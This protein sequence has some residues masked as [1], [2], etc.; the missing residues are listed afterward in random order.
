MG[1]ILK[2]M[3]EQMPGSFFGWDIFLPANMAKLAIDL[4]ITIEAIFFFSFF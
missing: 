1:N 3:I 4:R 2:K